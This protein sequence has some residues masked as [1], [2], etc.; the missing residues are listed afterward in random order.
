MFPTPPVRRVS[1]R[2]SFVL[3]LLS[4][5]CFTEVP[6]RPCAPEV[7]FAHVYRFTGTLSSHSVATV[8][9]LS[10][11][12]ADLCMGTGMYLV[13]VCA[14]FVVVSSRS[15]YPVDLSPL[16]RFTDIGTPWPKINVS[17]VSP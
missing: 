12:V 7:A 13:F 16:S 11:V 8:F 9:C 4:C 14:L 2:W 6:G 10:Y 5:I 1:A 3:V 17:R 15:C